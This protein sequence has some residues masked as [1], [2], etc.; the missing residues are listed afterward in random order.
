MC[1]KN[2][3]A[4]KRQGLFYHFLFFCTQPRCDTGETYTEES[5]CVEFDTNV[6]E[7]HA[8]HDTN[9][10]QWKELNTNGIELTG[11]DTDNPDSVK[12][13]DDGADAVLHK[14]GLRIARPKQIS[15]K[16]RRA[17]L[18]TMDS[19]AAIRAILDSSEATQ[20]VPDRRNRYGY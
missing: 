7:P 8:E 13:N 12:L 4:D 9:S 15:S 18:I 20:I 11:F 3:T 19:A 14:N 2:G 5:G 17:I 1:K 10:L 6:T 16:S